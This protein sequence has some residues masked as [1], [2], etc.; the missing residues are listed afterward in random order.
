[1]R[2]G[3]CGRFGTLALAAVALVL[4]A[5]ACDKPDASHVTSPSA[6]LLVGTTIGNVAYRPADDAPA[7]IEGPDGWDVRFENARFAELENGKESIQVVLQVQSR[8]GP[9]FEMW[10][11]DAD[12]TAFR[13]SGGSVGSYDG[14]VC[15]QLALESEGEALPLGDGPYTMTI[16]FRDVDAPQPLAAQALGVTGTPPR[17]T[18]T[19]PAENSPVVR[20]LLGCPRSVI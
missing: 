1:M 16:A 4:L 15:F 9:A 18:G 3:R 2:A 17:L 12:G 6:K 8:P 20:D 13:W 5:A 19:V 11:E 14:V 7:E 10:L